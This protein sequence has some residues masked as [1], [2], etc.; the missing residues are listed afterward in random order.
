MPLRDHFHPPVSRR[1]SWDSLHGMWPAFLV[2]DLFFLLP[3]GFEAKPHVHPGMSSGIDVGAFDGTHEEI[4]TRLDSGGGG[5]ATATAA[6]LAP[7][8]SI[9]ADLDGLDDYAVRIYDKRYER[10]LVASIEII[11]PG[12]KDRPASRR[13]MLSKVAAFL[14]QDVCV[15][16][17]DL[18]TS[19]RSNL[20]GELLE[21][22]GRTTPGLP[23]TYA[24]TLRRRAQKKKKPRLDAWLYPM[25]PGAELPTVPLWL[26]ADTDL[27][28]ML[29]LEPGYEESGRLLHIA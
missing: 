24:V 11:S 23:D 15:C 28:V 29:P 20:F 13:E 19:R 3:A 5:T 14:R 4:G 9:E 18:V 6:V 27:R 12:N 22:E 2:R 10:R 21:S 1:N 8:L 7:T 25:P 16:V 26:E 17:I